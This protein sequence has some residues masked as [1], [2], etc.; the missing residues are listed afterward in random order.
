MAKELKLDMLELLE[1]PKCVLF[2][3]PHKGVRRPKG[4]R[5]HTCILLCFALSTLVAYANSQYYL[6]LH[7]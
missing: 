4:G 3:R 1:V 7:G 2:V 6:S 5:C